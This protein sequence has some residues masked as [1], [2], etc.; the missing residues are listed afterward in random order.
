MTLTDIAIF[1]HFIKDRDLRKQFIK[2]YRASWK[3]AK[4]PQSIEE[5]FSNVEPMAVI[6]SSMRVCSVNATYGYDFWQ[7]LHQD[8]KIYYK[9]YSACDFTTRKD[10]MLEKLK[11]Y[12]QIL[13]ENWDTTG[14]PWVYEPEAVAYKRL[15]LQPPE[16]EE[17][18]EEP[19]AWN[20][21]GK[22]EEPQK[23]AKEEDCS[24]IHE[25][26]EDN[27]DIDFI[28]I[29][30]SRKAGRLVKGIMSVNTRN[31]N[32][33]CTV[34]RPD[35]IDLAKRKLRKVRLGRMGGGVVVQFNISQG[36]DTIV[37]SDGYVNINNA[38][39]IRQLCGLLS[40]SADLTYLRM[41]AI[42][43]KL[44]SVTYKLTKQ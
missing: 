40:I 15:G 11:G 30:P 33:R 39:L 18:D 8:W 14:K 13:R 12:F 5:F 44:N 26:Q 32:Y 36:T 43:D 16:D 17:T 10:G 21:P 22:A 23:P 34:N 25:Q 2:V 29:A 35:S 42:S 37:N 31:G 20:E 3:F 24:T 41:E 19:A 4:N 28:D 7:S 27:L 1:K 38:A 6:L 9:K